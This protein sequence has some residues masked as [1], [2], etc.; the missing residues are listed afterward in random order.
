MNKEVFKSC[1]ETVIKDET[2]AK[3]YVSWMGDQGTG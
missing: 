1:T 2:L 3:S